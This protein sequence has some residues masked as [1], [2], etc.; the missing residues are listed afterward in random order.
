MKLK[1]AG[2]RRKTEFSPNHVVNDL[3]IINQTAD[4]LRNLGAEVNLYDEGMITP[5]TLKEK[6]VFQWPRVRSDPRR[7]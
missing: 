5:E 4:E 2:V 1:F 6:L 3:L 7:S